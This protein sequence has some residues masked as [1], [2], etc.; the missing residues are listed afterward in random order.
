MSRIG[1]TPIAIPEQVTVSVVGAVVTVNGPRGELQRELPKGISVRQADG[2]L[3][4]VRADDERET[5][6]LHGLTRS[7]LANMVTGVT[8]GYEKRL[9]ISGV[10]YRATKQGND[11]EMAVGFSHTVRKSA[12]AGIEFEV[13]APTRITVRGIDKELVGQTAAEIRAIRKPEPYK[14]KGIRYEG[15]YVRRKAGKAAKAAAR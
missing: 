7:L 6:A 9:E 11:L 13:P 1:Q 3:R 10:G 12:P 8:Q 14:G 4:I 2:E 5:R 15:E